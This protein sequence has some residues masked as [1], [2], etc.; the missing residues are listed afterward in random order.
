MSAFETMEVPHTPT[1]QKE[2][3]GQLG[4][5]GARLHKI[6]FGH[7]LAE[8]TA[9]CCILFFACHSIRRIRYTI[10]RLDGCRRCR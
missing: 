6:A 5:L 2:H 1:A 4:M 3:F 8:N 7:T 9:R 10:L